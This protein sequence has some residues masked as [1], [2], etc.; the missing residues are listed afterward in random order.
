M[1]DLVVGP[2]LSAV[3]E[4]TVQKASSFVGKEFL[5]F[6]HVKEDIEKLRTTLKD[7]HIRAKYVEGYLYTTSG[8]DLLSN[9][10]GKLL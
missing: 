10:L 7:V 3:V 2:I 5:A 8:H 1:V 6:Y 9:W 4:A